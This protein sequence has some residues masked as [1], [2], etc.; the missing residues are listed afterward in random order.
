[1]LYW[2][3][4]AKHTNQLHERE[5]EMN[6]LSET[7]NPFCPTFLNVVLKLLQAQEGRIADVLT[8]SLDLKLVYLSYSVEG[9]QQNNQTHHNVFMSPDTYVPFN[10]RYLA[11]APYKWRG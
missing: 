1:M 6:V 5:M 9:E 2:Q 11:A 4:S 3:K 10:F 7:M 8:V